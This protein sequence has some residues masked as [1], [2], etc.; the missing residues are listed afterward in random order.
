MTRIDN[1][2]LAYG[3]ALIVAM[4]AASIARGD[5]PPDRYTINASQGLVTDVRTGLVWQQAPNAMQ[6]TWDAANTYCRGLTLGGMTGFRI[7]TLKELMTLVDPT[8]V[9]PAIDTKAF[10]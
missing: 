8:R 1:K 2:Q 7:P 3:L 5:A 6:Y 10:P 9:R 4:G